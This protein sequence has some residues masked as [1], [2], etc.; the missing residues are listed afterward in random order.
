[1]LEQQVD[2]VDIDPG[3]P[4]QRAVADDTVEDTVQH[5]QHP[6]RQK[7]L[8]QVPD[9]ITEDAGAGVHVGRLSKGVQAALG[10]EFDGQRNVPGFPF[11]L[12][13]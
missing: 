3:V 9:V 8:A 2:L 13:Q 1:M 7:L 4:P 5:Y 12:A 10:K 11:R 6:H